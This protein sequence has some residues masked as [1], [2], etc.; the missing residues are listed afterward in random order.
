MKIH[1]IIRQKRKEKGMTQEELARYVG[2]SAPAVNKWERA[3]SYPDISLLPVLA[4]YFNISVDELLGYEPQMIKE[5][6]KKLY[7]MLAERFTKEPYETVK[8]ACDEYVREYYSCFPLLLQMAGLFLNHYQMAPEPQ[9]AMDEIITLLDR[10][11]EDTEDVHLAKDAATMRAGCCLM[12]KQP[13]EI[14]TMLGEEIHPVNQ[15]AE[16]QA[17][18]YMLRGN[19]ENAERVLQISMYQ[20]LLI[21]EGDAAMYIAWQKTA[22]EK[23]EEMIRRTL[24]VADIYEMDS[25]HFNAI[26]QVYLAC[27]QYFCIAE[28]EEQAIEMIEKYVRCVLS[29]EMPLRLHGDAYFDKVDGWLSEL[30]LGQEAPRGD[31]MVRESICQAVA[32]NALFEG[33][34]GNPRFEYLVKRLEEF[35]AGES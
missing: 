22:S 5:D 20:H 7:H 9:K 13:D 15:D 17:H 6:I 10:V 31:K 14:L 4:S 34:S 28:K 32:Q 8:A 11:I 19:G 18:A 26:E 23:A 27:A 29:Q 35:A 2:V 1:E 25:L 33:L 16:L 30:A 24:A 21:L 12:M 3:Q